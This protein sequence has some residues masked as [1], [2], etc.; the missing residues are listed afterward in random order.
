MENI[1]YKIE[2]LSK[3]LSILK[4]LKKE[5][6][7]SVFEARKKGYFNGFKDTCDQILHLVEGVKWDFYNNRYKIRIDTEWAT[8]SS[9]FKYNDVCHI[10]DT[11]GYGKSIGFVCTDK[12]LFLAT[13]LHHKNM[14]IQ[15]ISDPFKTETRS[16]EDFIKNLKTDKEFLIGCFHIYAMAKNLGFLQTYENKKLKIKKHYILQKFES[17]D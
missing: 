1:N 9:D 11:S 7:D 6:I 14:W 3:E 13:R 8:S 12:A 15:R 2:T 5:S 4:T 16:L 17:E 10:Y